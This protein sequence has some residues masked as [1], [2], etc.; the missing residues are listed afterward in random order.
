M[1]HTAVTAPALTVLDLPAGER[2]LIGLA[3][4]SA[5]ARTCWAND[6]LWA[7]QGMPSDAKDHL[8]DLRTR[9]PH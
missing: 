3:R 2:N 5:G 4:V 8:A 9:Q 1:A 7:P 6:T